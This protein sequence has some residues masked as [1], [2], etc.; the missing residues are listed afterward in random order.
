MLTV[1]GYA[2]GSTNRMQM[3]I[4]Q[5]TAIQPISGLHRPR[6]HGPGAKSGVSRRRNT[7]T[8]YAM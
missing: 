6:F 7:G 5:P 4:T 8:T 1:I 3:K 2:G